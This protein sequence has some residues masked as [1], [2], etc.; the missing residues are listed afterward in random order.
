MCSAA[1]APSYSTLFLGS[2]FGPASRGP[3][4]GASGIGAGS[5][6]SGKCQPRVFADRIFRLQMLLWQVPCMYVLSRLMYCLIQA[7]HIH[8]CPP[9]FASHF[10]EQLLILDHLFWVSTLMGESLMVQLIFPSCVISVNGVDTPTDLILLEM[11]D[12][13]VILGMD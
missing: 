7:L 11:M 8:M 1:L 9:Y 12:F 3:A 2:S 13:D 5:K 6:G 4:R 10:D